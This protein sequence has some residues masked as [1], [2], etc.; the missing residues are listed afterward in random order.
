MEA[1]VVSP[2]AAHLLDRVP[3][4]AGPIRKGFREPF[5]EHRKRLARQPDEHQKSV[6]RPGGPR[7]VEERRDVAVV[8]ARDDR[9]DADAGLD[10]GVREHSKRLEALGRE[11]RARLDRAPGCVVRERNREADGDLRLARHRGQQRNVA[12]DEGALRNHSDRVA[13]VETDLETTPRQAVHRL[14]RLVAV[15]VAGEGD[16]LASPGRPQEFL[17]KPLGDVRLD[18]DLP[19]E[20]CARPE[21][22]IL[23]ARPRIA[24]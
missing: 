20:V 10:P 23:V 14:E 19:V 12:P 18:D 22:E 16:D 3:D 7:S 24:V 9:G 21:A 4:L 6:L 8:Q 2:A 13:E 17:A 5:L 15:R 11:A 1:G